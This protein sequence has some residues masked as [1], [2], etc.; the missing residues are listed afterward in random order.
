MDLLPPSPVGSAPPQHH[1]WIQPCLY[2]R[3]R[4]KQG[5]ATHR[6]GAPSSKAA[7]PDLAIYVKA[8]EHNL[9]RNRS[10]RHPLG[11]T[12]KCPNPVVPQSAPAHRRPPLK[13][14]LP[15]TVA[16][17]KAQKGCH[18]H[19]PFVFPSTCLGSLPLFFSPS[20]DPALSPPICSFP[21]LIRQL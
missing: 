17:G 14:P 2:R 18:P 10:P 21:W 12:R 20:I 8:M 9:T 4:A 5:S 1:Y 11:V 15:A 3:G 6:R 16:S 13:R 7:P 19:H